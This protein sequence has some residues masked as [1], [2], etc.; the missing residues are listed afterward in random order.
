MELSIN[1]SAW[2][3][4]DCALA[5]VPRNGRFI[6]VPHGMRARLAAARPD[7]SIHATEDILD[8]VGLML[9][10][11]LVPTALRAE[12]VSSARR[13]VESYLSSAGALC[14]MPTER[15]NLRCTYCYETFSRGRMSRPVIDG[16]CAF[17]QREVPRYSRYDLAW[18]GGEPLL[19]PDIVLEVSKSFRAIPNPD[20]APRQ[21]SITTN[22][23][24][25]TAELARQ[26]AR[27][28]LDL[29]QVTIDGPRK[30][31]DRQR[32]GV[33][34]Q[35]TYD[36][37]K[38]GVGHLLTHTDA[39][40]QVRVN[41]NTAEQE[42][43][44]TIARW[45]QT[46]VKGMLDEWGPRVSVSVVPIWKATTHSIEGLC[47][48]DIEAF[49][50][51]IALRKV[52]TR[53]EGHD[54]IARLAQEVGQT[55]ALACYAGKPNHYVL[56]SDGRVYKCTVAFDLESNQ[57]GELRPDGFLEVDTAREALWT[58]A[59]YLTD[60]QCGHCSFGRSCIGIHCP[61]ERLQTSK[62]P[63]PSIKSF[64]KVLAG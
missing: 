42:N 63:C 43:V 4:E 61:L 59:N 36:R 6:T 29:V 25:V 58:E 7:G 15:C 45:M 60:S 23:T 13:D 34:G 11:V 18:F 53:L 22:A 41:A 51:W 62:P 56:G 12:L 2:L 24:T 38:R 16:L 3:A 31:H 40:V 49:N 19:C 26:L 1:P 52:A 44:E 35:P 5:A 33:V 47:L 14:V 57:I 30:L 46:C 39:C 32:L 10:G 17:L 37:V 8:A 50:G 28:D 20:L 9:E 54:F 21:V 55:G 64:F 48:K 27:V